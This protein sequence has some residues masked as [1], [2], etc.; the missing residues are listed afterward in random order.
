[1]KRALCNRSMSAA[2]HKLRSMQSALVVYRLRNDS[3]S[4]LE[5]RDVISIDGHE[6][7]GHAA[8]ATKLWREMA[9]ARSLQ[10]EVRRLK[11]DSERYDIGLEETGLTVFE[12]LPLRSRCAGDFTFREVRHEIANG[13]PVRVFA[14]QQ[15]RPCSVVAYHFALPPEFADSA[16]LHAGELTLDAET[17]QVV[18][19]ERNVYAGGPGKNA[20]RVAHIT[21]GYTDSPFGILVPKTIEIETFVPRV[22]RMTNVGVRVACA[23]GAE[24]WPV[25]PL[26]GQR[27]GESFSACSL[28]S[29]GAPRQRT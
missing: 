14:Y 29:S 7:K 6:V 8:R 19:E 5:Y 15:V 17:G 27:R 4:V 1:M 2:S 22:I 20:P 21:L 28:S 10:E 23:H 12:G 13:R 11:A 25:L 16:L 26:R 18:R 24:L 9:A 3:E